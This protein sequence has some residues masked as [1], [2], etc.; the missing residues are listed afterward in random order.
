MKR[1]QP[2]FLRISTLLAFVLIPLGG[3][4]T[5]IYIP[6]LPAMSQHLGVSVQAVQLSLLL[7]MVSSGGSQLFIGSLLDSYGRYRFNLVALGLF[8]LASFT[9]AV[10]GNLYVIYAMRVLQGVTVSLI[11]VGK[12]AFFVDM[13]QGRQLKHYTSLFSIVWATAPI[14]APFIGGYLQHAWGWQASFYFLGIVTA[15]VLLFELIYS[16]E[17]LDTWPPFDGQHIRRVY[18]HMLGTADFVLGLLITGLSYALLVI[19][20]MVSP[21]IIEKI[22]GYTPVTTGYSS[23]L[24]GVALMSG[25]IVSK[26]LLNQPLRAKLNGAMLLQGITAVLMWVTTRQVDR[27]EV[28]LGFTFVLH[29]IAGF[30]FNN[31]YAYC[32]QRFT[33][34]AGTASGLTGGGIYVV[35]SAVSYGLIH[36]I[37][38][39][40]TQA[41][42]V[43]NLGLVAMLLLTIVVFQRMARQ[44]IGVVAAEVVTR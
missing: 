24:S 4:A 20:G 36:L 16:G 3:F 38:L 35:S 7:F 29:F 33:T 23:L 2:Q 17:S 10:T 40:N 11:I 18:R 34:H 30:L 37:D 9:I 41:L 26:L 5:D 32:L 8:A 21:F 15:L 14:L 1:Q 25:G 44:R 39:T 27:L 22:Y 43:V 12:R 28:L 31:L 42:A 6:S 13:Y 19:Y